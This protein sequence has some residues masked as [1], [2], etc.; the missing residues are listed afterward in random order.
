MFCMLFPLFLGELYFR[1]TF[2][3]HPFVIRLDGDATWKIVF[4]TYPGF[5]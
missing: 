5:F 4:F 3:D 1:E 2:L